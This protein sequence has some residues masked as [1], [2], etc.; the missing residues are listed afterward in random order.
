L[1]LNYGDFYLKWLRGPDSNQRPSGY[2]PDELPDCS[3]PRHQI[4]RSLSWLLFKLQRFL[5]FFLKWLR[6]PD[7][8]QRP[9]GYEPDELPDCSTPRHQIIR[10]LSWLLLNYGGFFDLYLKWLRG[11][12]SNQRPSGYEPDELPDCSTP[13]HLDIL[14][15]ISTYTYF[16]V[17][18]KLVAGAGFE[19]T[20]FGL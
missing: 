12:D 8:N 7:S 10:S 19:P 5:R 15:Y 2:E 3:T 17:H 9:S 4:V 18:F 13:R 1:I 6:G 11:P 14:K 16:Y 20:T